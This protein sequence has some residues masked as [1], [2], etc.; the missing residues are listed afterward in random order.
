MMVVGEDNPNFLYGSGLRQV[1]ERRSIEAQL[2]YNFD[3]PFLF[4]S[5]VDS[6]L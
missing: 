6:W 3:L 5:E 1:A 2:Q 4:D